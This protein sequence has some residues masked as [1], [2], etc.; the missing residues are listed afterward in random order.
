MVLTHR[1]AVSAQQ[2]P[3]SAPTASRRSWRST[4]LA[5]PALGI[6]AAVV[7]VVVAWPYLPEIL[8]LEPLAILLLAALVV[9]LR[10]G[11]L[12]LFDRSS[13]SISVVPTLAAG[14][15]FGI[16]GAVVVAPVSAVV[17][18]LRH[19]SAWYKVLYNASIYI[20]ASAAA[21]WTFH[22]F[23]VAV[24]P[25]N[26]VPLLPAGAL[27]GVVYYLHTFLTAGAIAVERRASPLRV[28]AEHF[29]WLFPE[30]AVL[31]VMSLLLG[32][33]HAAFGLAGTAVFLLPPL[34]MHFVAK[35][36]VDRTTEGVRQLRALN[37]ELQDEIAHRIA[38]EEENARLTR[39]AARAAALEEMNRLKSRFI[40]VASHELRTPLTAIV[41]Y[42][43]LLLADTP[44]DDP[45]HP[46]I[47]ETN[48]SAQQLIRLVENML[49]A[50]RMEIGK[51]A[52]NPVDVDLAAFVPALL[53]HFGTATTHALVADV[54]DDARHARADPIRLRQILLNLVGN[55]IK[56]SPEG[57]PVEVWTRRGEPGF[58]EILVSDRGLG[59]PPEQQ[60]HIFDPYQ[61]VD[62]PS[63][64]RIE[65]TGLG[66]YI[67]RSLA[68][69][70]GGSVRVESQV[71]RGS[72][73]IVSLPA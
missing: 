63:H 61:R 13:F 26:L 60:A 20:V 52:V 68:E 57:G 62:D 5:Q 25:A 28:W 34:M 23:G 17:R 44:P 8:D 39:E 56:Y 67:V 24:E 38:A 16:P 73:F 71:G 54:A 55:A 69:L 3:D 9:L 65:G 2:A 53:A 47:A 58:V 29:R 49:D 59:I 35:Q 72:T 32:L 14:V 7:A 70:H 40:S 30:Y 12:E 18:G 4:E 37:A 50:S 33:A 10:S 15:L 31:G 6:G 11:S 42:T 27:A 22:A 48:Q 21:A 1:P 36:Y 19:R 66:L 51:L 43:E 41:G 64:K 46:M 45:R